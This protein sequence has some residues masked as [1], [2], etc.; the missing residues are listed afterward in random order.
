ML[1]ATWNVNS[2]RSRLERLLAWLERTAPDVVCLQ[3]TKVET[4]KF[5]YE[6]IAEAGYYAAVHG[7]KTYNGVAILSRTEPD[8]VLPGWADVYDDEQA[9]LLAA[10]IQGVRIITAYMPNGA[11]PGSEKWQYKLDWLNHLPAYLDATCD[12]GTPLVLGGDYNVAPEARDAAN[13]EKW[14][15]SV[16]C[17]PEARAALQRIADWG[18]VDTMRLHHEGPG[19]YSWWDYRRLAFPKGDGLRIDH[20]FATPALADRCTDAWVDRDERKGS[21]PSDHAPVL[22]RF[23]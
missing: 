9:R 11:Q 4:A 22:A 7:Q 19:P 6:A 2:V 1:V 8:D 10:T 21:K 3:E 17:A 16:L 14:V 20:L 13:P 12:P 5:P 23:E 18:L 15:E